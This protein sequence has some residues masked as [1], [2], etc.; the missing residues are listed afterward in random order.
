MS[1]YS[2]HLPQHFLSLGDIG[3]VGHNI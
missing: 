1:F 2:G 3:S